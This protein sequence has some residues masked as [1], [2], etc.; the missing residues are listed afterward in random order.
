MPVL[1]SQDFMVVSRMNFAGTSTQALSIHGQRALP[2]NR[3][4]TGA[5]NTHLLISPARSSCT[6]RKMFSACRHRRATAGHSEEEVGLQ[7]CCG[8]AIAHYRPDRSA[9]ATSQNLRCSLLNAT[10]YGHES[11]MSIEAANSFWQCLHYL[12]VSTSG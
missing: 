10:T 4:R 1:S 3:D 7:R 9:T 6:L 5:R 2:C 11:K 12:R 8:G